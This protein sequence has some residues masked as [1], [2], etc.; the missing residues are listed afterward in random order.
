MKQ[1]TNIKDMNLY[2]FDLNKSFSDKRHLYTE[3]QTEQFAKGFNYTKLQF[4][5]DKFPKFPN[6]LRKIISEII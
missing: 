6:R 4:V 2:T 3:F 1:I 5:K